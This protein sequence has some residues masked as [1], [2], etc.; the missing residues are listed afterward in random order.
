MIQKNNPPL[1]EQ[2]MKESEKH[3]VVNHNV[4]TVQGG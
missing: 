1:N 4:M 2:E 3:D